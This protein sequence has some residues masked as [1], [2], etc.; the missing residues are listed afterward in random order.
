[1]QNAKTMRNN[2]YTYLHEVDLSTKRLQKVYRELI[3]EL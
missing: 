3:E 2:R 1:M